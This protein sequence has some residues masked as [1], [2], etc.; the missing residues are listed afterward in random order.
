M[1]IQSC[2]LLAAVLRRQRCA[3]LFCHGFLAQSL[4]KLPC[5]D[6]DY[7]PITLDMNGQVAVRAQGETQPTE[8]VLTQS[9]RIGD[10]LCIN[11]VVGGTG[12]SHA[13]R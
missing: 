9:S 5:N 13:E 4:P 11:T 6:E 1:H 7:Q 12:V 2:Q 10:P 3:N 8:L